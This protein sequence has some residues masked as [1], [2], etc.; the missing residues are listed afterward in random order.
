MSALAPKLI[1]RRTLWYL[2]YSYF[3]YG[4]IRF[5]SR[6]GMGFWPVTNYKGEGK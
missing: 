2:I 3:R 4:A 5:G 6:F 1:W